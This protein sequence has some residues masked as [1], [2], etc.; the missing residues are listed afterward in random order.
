MVSVHRYH[1]ISESSHRIMNPLSLEKLLLVADICH[2]GTAS[3]MLDLA[4]GKG[5]MLC[6]LAAK[7]G[8]TGIGV[9]IYPPVVAD[10]RARAQEVGV[11]GTVDFIEGDVAE[12]QDLGAPFDVV[13]CIGA[14]WIGNGL[15]GTLALMKRWVK[16][17]G[18]ILVGEV[19]WAEPPSAELAMRYGQEFADLAGTLD[20]FEAAGLDLTEMVLA[21]SDDW[22]RYTASQWLNVS[23]WLHSN[24]DD[25]DAAEVRETRDRSRRQYLSEERGRLGWGVFVGRAPTEPA[26]TT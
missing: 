10:A 4:S 12:V 22:D 1:E 7:F 6:Q 23:D 14:T 17:G 26:P 25:P 15:A 3:R 20:I 11:A 24:P 8:S 13:S 2:I 9:D 21:S 18:W 5:E 16:P 19:Y